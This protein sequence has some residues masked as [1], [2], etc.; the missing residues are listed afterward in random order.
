MGE[1]NQEKHSFFY[2]INVYKKSEPHI[3]SQSEEYLE[4]QILAKSF[5]K[6][7]MDIL[8]TSI[9]LSKNERINGILG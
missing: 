1:F 3:C 6:I 9:F 8:V 2:R 5:F 7:Q 4:A